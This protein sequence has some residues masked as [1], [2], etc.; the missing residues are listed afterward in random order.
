M[1]TGL[2]FATSAKSRKK[3]LG[4]PLDQI[5][6]PLLIAQCEQAL[7]SSNED[8]VGANA[9]FDSETNSRRI[10]D[11]AVEI[12]NKRPL[13]LLQAEC[14]PSVASNWTTSKGQG[15]LKSCTYFKSLPGHRA[16]PA[17]VCQTP[18][19]FNILIANCK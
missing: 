6:D 5:L 17:T 15:L 3:I 10:C 14:I 8:V 16:K 2:R 7:T 11:C 19:V 18:N 1:L 4:P 12:E 9:K 13:G